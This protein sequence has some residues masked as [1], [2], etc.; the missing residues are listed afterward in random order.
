MK[1]PQLPDQIRVCFFLSDGRLNSADGICS[2]ALIRKT[3][4]LPG[5]VMDERGL[6]TAE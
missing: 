2:P 4:A 5:H 3:K 1:N 6:F